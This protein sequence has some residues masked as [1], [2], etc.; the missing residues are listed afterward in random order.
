[1]AKNR[2]QASTAIRRR[3]QWHEVAQGISSVCKR[4]I[5]YF[6]AR[7]RELNEALRKDKDRSRGF[8][9]S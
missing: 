4:F 5:R 8:S 2:M 1:V 7:N 3:T 6:V 9:S